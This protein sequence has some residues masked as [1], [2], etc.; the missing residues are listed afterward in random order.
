MLQRT[1]RWFH[2][3]HT[4]FT[5][6]QQKTLECLQDLDLALASIVQQIGLSPV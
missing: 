3:Y 2:V 6:T 5:L 1:D 4:Y